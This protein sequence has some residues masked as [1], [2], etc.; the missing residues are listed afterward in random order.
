MHIVDLSEETRYDYFTCLEEWS[1]EMKDGFYRKECM[2]Y[3][4]VLK[5][6]L[7][8]VVGETIHG[9]AQSVA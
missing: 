5:L 6:L 9:P 8:R 1:D 2:V 7:R 4:R 3:I